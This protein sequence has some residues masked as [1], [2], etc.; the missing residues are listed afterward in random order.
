M[1]TG[2]STPDLFPFLVRSGG[3]GLDGV[4]AAPLVVELAGAWR[5]AAIADCAALSP[6]AF[7]ALD[8]ARCA[9]ERSS[10]FPT[11]PNP[12]PRGQSNPT[13]DRWIQH[14]VAQCSVSIVMAIA[15]WMTAGSRNLEPR[16]RALMGLL[17]SEWEDEW[18]GWY[19]GPIAVPASSRVAACAALEAAEYLSGTEILLGR[20]LGS[21]L[22][23]TAI[24]Y[25]AATHQTGAKTDDDA[26]LVGVSLSIHWALT[27][28]GLGLGIET[29][30]D[31]RRIAAAALAGAKAQQ[32]LAG[33]SNPISEFAVDQA[34]ISV[35]Q[36]RRL[37]VAQRLR[38]IAAY[39]RSD[40]DRDAL[41]RAADFLQ[42][43]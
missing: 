2:S 12:K 23:V 13:L 28:Q 42:P 40:R 25:F 43:N 5:R 27:Q 36:T 19:F 16:A 26:E 30:P 41:L 29:D 14:A 17:H 24:E 15:D 34:L 31:A 35:E 32:W 39:Q 37:D 33:S 22:P 18:D 8:S 1:A 10:D 4:E 21:R 9:L 6:I 38:A 3:A 11:E 20:V 7:D